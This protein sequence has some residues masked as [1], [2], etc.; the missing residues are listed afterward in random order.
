[1][2][3]PIC[4]SIL[5][6]SADQLSFSGFLVNGINNINV[7]SLERRFDLPSARVAWISSSYDV[8]AAVA[9]LVFGYLGTFAHKGRILTATAL[10]MSVGAFVMFLPHLLVGNYELGT[11]T[12]DECDIHGESLFVLTHATFC[13]SCLLYTSP[14]PRDQRGSR[15]PSSA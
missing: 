4:F 6:F 3:P 11:R 12:S 2:V 15:M 13:V 8:S 7:S 10:S 1:M 5:A 14:S 9:C